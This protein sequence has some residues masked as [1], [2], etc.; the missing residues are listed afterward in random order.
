MPTDTGLSGRQRP[1]S[2]SIVRNE[3]N[4]QTLFV[5]SSQKGITR[6]DGQSL[7]TKDQTVSEW[8]RSKGTWR[9]EAVSV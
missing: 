7:E 4:V 9:H 3:E 5:H 2:S 8:D 6:G 1:I